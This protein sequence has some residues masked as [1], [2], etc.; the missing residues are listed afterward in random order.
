MAYPASDVVL[1][2]LVVVLAM[3]AGQS[4]RSGLSLVM[5]GIVAFAIAD[6]SFAYFT[7]LNNYGFGNVLDTGWVAGYLLIGM[8][9]VRT[10][11]SSPAMIA[12]PDPEVAESES[13][14]LSSVLLPYALAAL[15]GVVATGRLI[16]GRP[17]GIF[18]SLEGL[19]LVTMLG[20]RQ[21]VTMVDN[22]SLNRRLFVKVELGT[23]ELR[24]R[25]ARYSALVERSSDPITIVRDD[26][27]ILY[28]SPSITRLLGWK[29]SDA[30]GTSYLD[31]LHPEDHERWIVVLRRLVADPGNEV[32]TEWRLL[33]MNGTWRTFESVLTNLIG[34]PSVGGLVL[35]SRDVTD[36]RIAEAQLRHQAFH[37]PLTGL[38]NRSLFA[39]HLDRA[40]RRR[41]RSGGGVQ[42]MFIDL[43]NFKAVND[44]RGRALGDELLQ[45][46][47]RRLESTFRDADLIARIGGDQFAVLSEVPPLQSDSHAAA[48]RLLERFSEPFELDAESV[49]VAVCVGIA[50]DA[51]G[52]ETDEEL[53]RHA[54]LAVNSAKSK[55]KQSCAVYTAALHDPILKNMRVETEL[56]RALERDELVVHYQPIVDVTS[57]RVAGVEALVRWNHPERGLV[58][59]YEFI[60][61]AESSGLIVPLGDWVL[62]RSC[63]EVHALTLPRGETL[64]LSVNVSPRQLSNQRFFIEVENALKTS[65]FEARLLTL[66]VTESLFVDDVAGRL[67]L[68]NK[69]RGTHVQIAIDDFGTGYSS[70]KLLGEM[71]VDI[72]KID[73]SFI[74]HVVTSPESARLVQM[75]LH[76]AKDLGVRT[77]A[78]GVEDQDQLET[79]QNMGCQLIQGYYFSKPI[80]VQELQTLLQV[81]FPALGNDRKVA[82]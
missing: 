40:V 53:M 36:Q 72:L 49:M 37:D 22:V 70:L 47:A 42:V 73:K 51:T 56:R 8:G 77:V 71:P 16:Q 50:T 14:T 65:A 74:D 10:V 23:Q 64:R 29:S 12:S 52:A 66:E 6:S 13:V 31:V 75:I 55:G 3:H 11:S 76:L 20:L 30:V 63:R 67:D 82:V 57:G 25:E 80:P 39:E 79:L 38:A 78:E 59:P 27:T 60:S 21:I 61:I 34:E 41:G 69:L 18:L 17:F 45:Q 24:A 15:A 54:D 81:G 7:E 4:Y 48:D 32:T 62:N 68:L 43:E 1:V 19:I 35:N 2:S 33:H 28:Q 5:L 9:A 46:V 44:L 58:G 26:A